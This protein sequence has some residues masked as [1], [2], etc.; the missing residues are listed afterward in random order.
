MA[1]QQ[2]TT[3]SNSQLQTTTKSPQIAGQASTNNATRASKVQPGTAT[4]LLNSKD[5]IPLEGTKSLKI[6]LSNGAI[7]Q[8]ASQSAAT[9]PMPPKHQVNPVLLGVSA[10]LFITAIVLVWATMRSA[11]NTT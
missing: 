3:T 11:K 4:A 6:S 5:G 10:L 1:E 2:L 7:A 8:T 9:A